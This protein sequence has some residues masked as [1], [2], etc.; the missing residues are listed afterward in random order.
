MLKTDQDN[1]S[2]TEDA[3]REPAEKIS[4]SVQRLLLQ[5]VDARARHLGINP[6]QL[7]S[8]AACM[9]IDG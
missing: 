1:G 8:I 3:D 9:F 6:S 7:F 2:A 4:I 5:R